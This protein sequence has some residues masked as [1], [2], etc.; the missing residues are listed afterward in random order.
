MPALV[1][2]SVGSSPG[3]SDD[4]RTRRGRGPRNSGENS[5]RKRSP[6]IEGHCSRRINQGRR[7]R[8]GGASNGIHIGG[9]SGPPRFREGRVVRSIRRTAPFAWGTG[10]DERRRSSLKEHQGEET[11]QRPRTHASSAPSRKYRFAGVKKSARIVI[12]PIRQVPRPSD[13]LSRGY[14]TLQWWRRESSGHGFRSPRNQHLSRRA[15]PD[16][17]VSGVQFVGFAEIRPPLFGG[18]EFGATCASPLTACSTKLF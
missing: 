13:S 9:V 5:S 12:P 1:K 4:E 15:H 10:H 6:V 11:S 14:R 2:S 3:T 18:L 8:R 17:R 16:D 7:P